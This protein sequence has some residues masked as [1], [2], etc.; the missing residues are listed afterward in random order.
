MI[1]TEEMIKASLF[2]PGGLL[3]TLPLLN[4]RKD[5]FKIHALSLSLWYRSLIPLELRKLFRTLLRERHADLFLLV[6]VEVAGVPGT[7]AFRH[8]RGFH[9]RKYKEEEIL[10]TL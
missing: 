10:L 6:V 1:K 9:L 3:C 4:R 7:S 2:I 5:R 8:K